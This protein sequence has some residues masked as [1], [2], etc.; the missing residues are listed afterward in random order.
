VS[1][2]FRILNEQ[3]QNFNARFALTKPPTPTQIKVME[4]YIRLG[5]QKAVAN[6]LNLSYQTVRNHLEALY[7]RLGV[8]GVV[9]ALNALGWIKV[10]NNR[11]IEPCG[12]L[13]YCSRHEGHRGQHGGYRPF[14]KKP[15]EIVEP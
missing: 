15:V 5:S 4:A 2:D 8:S 1:S 3:T 13:A 7:I 6:E 10:P 9:E 14:I 12:W 11:G